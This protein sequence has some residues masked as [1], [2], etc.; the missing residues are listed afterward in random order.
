MSS[1]LSWPATTRWNLSPATGLAGRVTT[2]TVVDAPVS[3]AVGSNVAVGV[4][5][6]VVRFVIVRSAPD[7]VTT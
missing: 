4:K 6:P 7:A 3:D 1:P 5:L 2:S